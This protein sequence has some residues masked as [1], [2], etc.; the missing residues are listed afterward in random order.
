MLV[1]KITNSVR[2]YLRERNGTSRFTDAALVDR[3]NDVSLEVSDFLQFG[4]KVTGIT[5]D[6]DGHVYLPSDLLRIERVNVKGFELPP[7]SPNDAQLIHGQDSGGVSGYIFHD[8]YIQVLPNYTEEVT[9]SY[10]S[11][12]PEVDNI[13]QDVIIDE[14]YRMSLV[15]GIAAACFIELGDYQRGTY[16]EN[17]FEKEKEARRRQLRNKA[18]RNASG[19]RVQ[20]LEL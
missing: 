3:L 7:L 2:G 13:D 1:T 15:F 12:I 6:G 10:I 14:A 20:G 11:R 5:P 16:F 18:W 17:K 9:L 19:P 8:N 4:R